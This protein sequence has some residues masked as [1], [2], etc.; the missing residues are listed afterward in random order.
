MKKKFING[1][2]WGFINYKWRSKYSEIK[3]NLAD[4]KSCLK[5]LEYL[6]SSVSNETDLRLLVK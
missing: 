4:I 6:K 5:Y 1:C 3:F 2:F